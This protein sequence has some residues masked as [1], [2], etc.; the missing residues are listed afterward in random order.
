MANGELIIA[1]YVQSLSQ[2]LKGLWPNRA[3]IL[4]EVEAHLTEAAEHGSP[5][6]AVA[7]FGTEKE[8]A[9]RFAVERVRASLVDLRWFGAGLIALLLLANVESMFPLEPV[10]RAPELRPA[11]TSILVCVGFVLQ[12]LGWLAF[13]LTLRLRAD[14]VAGA[15]YALVFALVTTLSS[16]ELVSIGKHLASLF[17][18][19]TYSIA[20]FSLRFAVCIAIFLRAAPFALAHQA[21]EATTA[22]ARGTLVRITW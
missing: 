7:D 20:A 19:G 3:R 14:H 6:R 13:L 5:A 10:F 15:S 8:V 1:Q 17:T 4:E 16:A 22:K 11:E 9:G 18:V 12:A 2:N 21:F